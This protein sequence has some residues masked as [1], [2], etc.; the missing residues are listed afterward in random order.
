MKYWS[1]LLW[2]VLNT[3][4]QHQ[5]TMLWVKAYLRSVI[6]TIGLLMDSGMTDMG[7][8]ATRPRPDGSVIF[9]DMSHVDS[10]SLC[11]RVADCDDHNACTTDACM[12]GTGNQRPLCL[13]SGACGQCDTAGAVDAGQ[14]E[15]TSPH[16]NLDT[17][18]CEGCLEHS[19]CPATACKIAARKC[20][21]PDNIIYVRQGSPKQPCEDVP[22]M[23]G[24]YDNPYCDFEL[25]TAAALK[26]G[27]NDDYT[28]IARAK[29]PARLCN[30][31]A[32]KF[33]ASNGVRRERQTARSAPS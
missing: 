19:E 2:F 31:R 20:F 7:S 17:N 26:G 28:I 4:G 25:A 8:D 32:A 11:V 15:A 10:G 18:M 12:L 29:T 30:S 5:T 27:A 24:G 23:G 3:F 9:V 6:N 16:C 13:A 21:P 1:I 33:S 22:G 14:C